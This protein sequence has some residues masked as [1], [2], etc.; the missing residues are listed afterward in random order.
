VIC[1][2]EGGEEGEAEE[3]VERVDGLEVEGRG[4]GDERDEEAEDGDDEGV[5]RATARGGVVLALA[6]DEVGHDAEDDLGLLAWCFCEVSVWNELTQLEANSKR[7][8]AMPI[9]R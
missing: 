4:E 6:V 9:G 2:T 7:R 3:E 5:D 1:S 8:R